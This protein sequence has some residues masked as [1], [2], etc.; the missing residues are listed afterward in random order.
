MTKGVSVMKN[1]VKLSTM[2]AK[3]LGIDIEQM[4]DRKI[5]FFDAAEDVLSTYGYI[6]GISY[7]DGAVTEVV[8]DTAGSGEVLVDLLIY[9]RWYEVRV[10][11]PEWAAAHRYDLAAQI[12]ND[13]RNDKRVVY[14]EAKPSMRVL[15][16]SARAPWIYN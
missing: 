1:A 9:N 14:D 5:A 7:C 8:L 2:V 12:S 3:A 4:S 16:D 15:P 11:A 13:L 6:A 10:Y